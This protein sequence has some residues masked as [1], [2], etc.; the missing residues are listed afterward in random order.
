MKKLLIALIAM[1][2]LCGCAKQTSFETVNDVIDA[3]VMATNYKVELQLPEEAA[4][5]VLEDG[6][7]MLYRCENYT[8]MINQLDGGD[9]NRTLKQVTGMDA[10]SL[11]VLK[12]VRNG[13]PCYRTA[14]ATAGEEEQKICRC[15][16]L[17]DGTMH[18]AV[19]VMADCEIADSLHQQWIHVMDSV[20]LVSTG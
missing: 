5:P 17:D 18:H 10:A 13:F 2:L 3:P 7:E 20:V 8:I 4:R 1:I 12:T 15:V 19:T 14:W 6:G 9:V 16:I 11:T